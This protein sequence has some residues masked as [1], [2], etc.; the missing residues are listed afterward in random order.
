MLR[1]F[2]ATV[3]F[4]AVTTQAVDLDALEPKALADPTSASHEAWLRFG[5]K[6]KAPPKPAEKKPES[7]VK[8]EIKRI[9][10]I[11]A[12]KAAKAAK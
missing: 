4:L 10:E 2:F 7:F 9:N 5:G 6:P 11:E 3:A 1:A 12:A 8:S